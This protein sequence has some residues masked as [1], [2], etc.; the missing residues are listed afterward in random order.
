MEQ[1]WNIHVVPLKNKIS[2]EE[3]VNITKYIY[4]Y[5]LI[6]FCKFCLHSLL[7]SVLIHRETSPLWTYKH[8][9]FIREAWWGHVLSQISALAVGHG[10]QGSSLVKA[11]ARHQ[12]GW[13]W[14]HD[15]YVNDG[16]WG[17]NPAG[18][19]AEQDGRGGGGGGGSGVELCLPIVSTFVSLT[20]TSF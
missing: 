10:A 19:N 17:W 9:R 6:I 13:W 2:K 1:H 3:I 16:E 15:F 4:I 18:S 5:N 8:W 11:R 12:R 7:S 20:L 14:W